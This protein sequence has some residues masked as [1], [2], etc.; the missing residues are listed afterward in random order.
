MWLRTS[1]L[2][3]SVRLFYTFNYSLHFEAVYCSLLQKR[4]ARTSLWNC[5]V[6][7]VV[8]L[9]VFIHIFVFYSITIFFN[10]NYDAPLWNNL[11]RYLS[12]QS[13]GLL[14][15]IILALVVNWFFCFAFWTRNYHNAFV[16]E[17][18]LLRIPC[19]LRVLAPIKARL[20][21]L[22]HP[23][24]LVWTYGAAP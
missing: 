18:I 1:R 22:F 16:V 24:I 10:E 13:F 8:Y 21:T 11:Q 19:G 15:P 14:I 23:P 20:S 7:L 2:F 6:C 4:N 17:P 9:I 3:C 12:E 5:S